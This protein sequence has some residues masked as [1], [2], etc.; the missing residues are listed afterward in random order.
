MSSII[1]HSSIYN[2]LRF[3]NWHKT[4]KTVL[5]CGAGGQSPPLG[6]FYSLGYKT[7]G[8]D[9]SDDMMNY[10]K[11]FEEQNNFDLNIIKADMRE[12]PFEDESFGNVFSYNTIFHMNR[13]DIAKA[14]S[15]MKRVLKKDGLM[16][17]N[18]IYIDDNTGNNYGEE[19]EPG[20]FWSTI[21][22]EEVLHVGFR[23]K[24]A[25]ELLDDM[26]ILYE[27]KKEFSIKYPN[28]FESTQ[29]YCE[30]VCKKI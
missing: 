2:F 7:A 19:R 4:E 10:A 22:G 29:A 25:N 6:L 15:E 27:E 26:E 17:V 1:Y 11:Q 23:E 13:K 28:G 20:E 21:E 5:D 24:E 8:I 18:F 9:I 3:V 14:L 12:I 30:Y 16:Y